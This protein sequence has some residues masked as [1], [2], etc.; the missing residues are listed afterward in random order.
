MSYGEFV[1]K[2]RHYLYLPPTVVRTMKCR[3]LP[4]AG[5]VARIWTRKSVCVCK[6]S[7]KTKKEM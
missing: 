4:W 6:S 2:E 1:N 7:S 3:T 5:N